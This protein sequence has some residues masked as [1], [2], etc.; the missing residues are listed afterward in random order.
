MYSEIKDFRNGSYRN[1]ADVTTSYTST[2]SYPRTGVLK[3][4]AAVNIG[5]GKADAVAS[6]TCLSSGKL[7]LSLYDPVKGGYLMDGD[8]WTVLWTDGTAFSE[9]Y[10]GVSYSINNGSQTDLTTLTEPTIQLHANGVGFV[11]FL[12]CDFPGAEYTMSSSVKYL[13]NTDKVPQRVKG[14]YLSVAAGDF[15]GDGTDTV[16][17]YIP[18]LDKPVIEEYGFE[19]RSV[20]DF[21]GWKNYSSTTSNDDYKINVKETFSGANYYKPYKKQSVVSDVYDEFSLTKFTIP[22]D[23]GSKSANPDYVVDGGGDIL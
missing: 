8:S 23:D 20:S 2:S 4:T 22:S 15:N 9:K 7:I 16:V 19:K 3:T 12:S 10:P 13:S 6:V 1:L 14:Q 17:A 5:N 21:G 11:G 18:D